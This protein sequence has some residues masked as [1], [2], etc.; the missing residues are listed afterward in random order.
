[1]MMFFSSLS[2]EEMRFCVVYNYILLAFQCARCAPSNLG[3]IVHHL[4][5]TKQKYHWDNVKQWAKLS[6]NNTSGQ[7]SLYIQRLLNVK[8]VS[9]CDTSYT[10]L[11]QPQTGDNPKRMPVTQIIA[12]I[13]R[14]F[15]IVILMIGVKMLLILY[16]GH[17]CCLAR[18]IQ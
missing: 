16:H 17:L 10:Y 5:F 2:R 12:T 7:T 1:M 14:I 13:H 18:M 3:R 15:M 4:L 11:F 9:Q 6:K 8:S